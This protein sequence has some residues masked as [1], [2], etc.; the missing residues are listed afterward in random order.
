[1]SAFGLEMCCILTHLKLSYII[2]NIY[3]ARHDEL[4]LVVLQ[5]F[6]QIQTV[7]LPCSDC[8]LLC[9]ASKHSFCEDSLKHCYYWNSIKGM[10]WWIW[11]WYLISTQA[12]G[13]FHHSYGKNMGPLNLGEYCYWSVFLAYGLLR[14]L[15]GIVIQLWKT[16][17]H[18]INCWKISILAVWVVKHG[19]D[20]LPNVFMF[21]G[22]VYT[23]T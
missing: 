7:H 4:D 9:I 16:T 11:V 3:S 12:S 21:R 17:L 1:M 14:I 18:S 8:K 22:H 19:L 2:C 23:F 5:G 15:F 10:H 20:Q 6:K 13:Y